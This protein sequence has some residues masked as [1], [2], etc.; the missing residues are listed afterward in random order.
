M[1]MSTRRAYRALLVGPRRPKDA[2]LRDADLRDAADHQHGDGRPFAG[3]G[4]GAQVCDDQHAD[5]GRDSGIGLI[6]SSARRLLESGRPGPDQVREGPPP[7]VGHLRWHRTVV[8]GQ[9]LAV[10]L[11]P[12][13]MTA[14][15]AV[16]LL[17]E[18]GDRL[19][20]IR[21]YGPAA[22]PAAGAAVAGPALRMLIDRLA[23]A[24]SPVARLQ[25]LSSAGPASGWADRVHLV[26]ALPLTRA[27][28]AG[29]KAVDD[30]PGDGLALL[31]GRA[32]LD[33]C[34]HLADCSLSIS[35]FVDT[36]DLAALIR[37]RYDPTA[38]AGSPWPS[39]IDATHHRHLPTAWT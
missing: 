32:V 29:A 17:P 20:E 27:A 24:D 23:G 34:R 19:A 14:T 5:G 39:E 2:D 35:R 28:V 3:H 21:Q 18:A 1:P 37:S 25:I 11:H 22:A 33:L 4:E 10:L 16:E 15:A 31:A 6:D 7:G 13:R 12:E 26:A 9:P 8:L 38:V 36:D 30:R